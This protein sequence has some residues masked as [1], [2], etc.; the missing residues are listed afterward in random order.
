[1]KQV[2]DSDHESRLLKK[3]SC[4]GIAVLLA[5][6]PPGGVARGAVRAFTPR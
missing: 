2:V 5:A 4:E 3:L 1:M 6:V